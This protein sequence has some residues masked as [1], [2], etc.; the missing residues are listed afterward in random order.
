VSLYNG[1]IAAMRTA[2]HTPNAT[3]PSL[4]SANPVQQIMAY[5][6]DQLNRIMTTRHLDLANA[7]QTT[8]KYNE[9]YSYDPNGNI[10]TLNRTNGQAES[11]DQLVYKYDQLNPTTLRNNQLKQVQDA[12][13]NTNAASNDIENQTDANNYLYDEIGNLIIDKSE[14]ITNIVWSIY[15]K[16][17]KVEKQTVLKTTVIEYLYDATGNRVRKNVKINNTGTS[18]ITKNITSF[19]YRD[20]QGNVLNTV[21]TGTERDLNNNDQIVNTT[22][23]SIYGSSRLGAYKPNVTPMSALDGIGKGRLTLGFKT[24]ELSNHLGNV[25]TT[26]SD[27]VIIEATLTKQARV[28][29]SQDYYPFGMAMTE[30]SY[31][32]SQETKYRYGFNGMEREEDMGEGI[33][34]FGARNLDVR[35]GRFLSVDPRKDEIHAQS[36]YVFANNIPTS[37]IDING[38]FGHLIVKFGIEVG[39]NIATQLIVA[40]LFDDDVISGE[41]SAWSKVSVIEAIGE[42]AVDMLGTTKLKMATNATIQIASYIDKVGVDNIEAHELLAAGA[43][44]LL[45]PMFGDLVGKYGTE[46]LVNVLKKAGVDDKTIRSL[47]LPTGKAEE[48][49]KEYAAEIKKNKSRPTKVSVVRD[50]ATGKTYKGKSGYPHPSKINKKLAKNSPKKSKEEWEVC[51]CAEFKAAND[52]LND[53]AKIFNLEVHTVTTKSGKNAD[54]CKNCS[55]TLQN[56]ATTSDKFKMQ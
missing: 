7:Y 56:T 39:I 51:N 55:I 50:L 49:V 26:I 32:E 21:S 38:E 13:G 8:A 28:L 48:E 18:T 42:G 20:A 30:R 43:I 3:N 15:G 52:A 33:Y 25:L 24:Y 17:L 44:G 14:N 10:L 45:E 2:I 54:R 1:N 19:Y 6:Y 53:G 36:T 35:L 16:V 27:N 5:Q 4:K 9:N 34:D 31:T 11:F 12:L 22:E 41:V 46:A 37:H 47:R 23:F 40:M 29:S